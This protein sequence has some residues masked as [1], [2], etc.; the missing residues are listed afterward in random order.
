MIQQRLVLIAAYILA[1]VALLAGAS[2]VLPATAA[3]GDIII[4]R[5]VQ[6]RAA[7]RKELVPDPNPQRVN[8][9]PDAVIDNGL[10]NGLMDELTDSDFAAVTSGTRL[11]TR[12]VQ[13][14][15]SGTAQGSL[16]IARYLDGASKSPLG[17]SGNGALNDIDGQVNRSVQQGLRP[18]QIL[19]R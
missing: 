5:E 19:Q 13:T 7:A 1:A 12:L 8:P 18:L 3:D 2:L 15:V 11:S 9:R 6:P 4:S 14:P 16:G 10:R 17:H